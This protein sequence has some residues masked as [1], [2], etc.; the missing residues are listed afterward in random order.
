MSRYGELGVDVRKRGVEAFRPS[1]HSLYPE[2]FCTVQPD[3]DNPGWGLVGHADSAGSKPIISYIYWRETGDPRWFGGLARDV[4]AMNLDDIICVAAR[5]ILFLDNVSLNPM[6]IDRL[7][8]LQALSDGFRDCFEGLRGLG[9]P[10]SFSGGETADLPD[11]VR[12]L[13]VSGFILGRVR[14]EEA[15][16]GG[17]IR[18]GDLIVGLR[19][20]GKARYEEEVNSGIMCNGLTLARCS[21]LSPEYPERYPEVSHSRGRYTGR[22][23]IEDY[24][25]ELGMT[26]GEALLSPTRV[27]AP[28]VVEA[29]SRLGDSIHGLV[30]NTGGGLTKC[31]RLGRGIRYVK[32]TLPEPDPIFTLIQREADIDPREMYMDFNMGI[33]FELIVQ[34][35]DAEEVID[36][37]ERFGVEAQVIGHCE[38]GGAENTLVIESRHG[39][40]QYQ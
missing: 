2:A 37:S 22:Y 14:L 23:R 6:N 3:P 4:V 36:I 17:M 13:D 1:I 26:L 27:F 40:F 5:P 16:T 33:G 38:E 29:L 24:L 20:G 35:E 39:K 21:L 11:Q 25:D 34:P 19:S 8:L 31:L 12:T 10:I 9:I 15:V 28:V 7:A 30:H 32:D 18:P